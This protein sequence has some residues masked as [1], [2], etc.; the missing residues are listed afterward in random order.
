MYDDLI[1]DPDLYYRKLFETGWI[2]EWIDKDIDTLRN[3]LHEAAAE[4]P[5]HMV[6]TLSEYSLDPE[7]FYNGDDYKGLLISLCR[8]FEIELPTENVIVEESDSIKLTIQTANGNITYYGTQEDDWLQD[9]FFDFIND[10]LLPELGEERIFY[11]LPP[12][13][14][15]AELVFQYPDVIEAAIDA[16]VIPDDDYFVANSQE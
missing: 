9:E 8:A 16:G 5:R 4:E 12:A 2:D 14:A 6:F 3:A 11:V 15:Q 7:G 13:E 1:K 10:E